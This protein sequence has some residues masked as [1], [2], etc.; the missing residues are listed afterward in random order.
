MIVKDMEFSVSSQDRFTSLFSFVFDVGG[1]LDLSLTISPHISQPVQIMFCT[2]K[3]LEPLRNA[4]MTFEAVCNELPLGLCSKEYTISPASTTSTA[5]VLSNGNLTADPIYTITEY[6]NIHRTATTSRMSLAPGAVPE[7]TTLRGNYTT[8]FDKVPFVPRP[9]FTAATMAPLSSLLSSVASI[10]AGTDLDPSELNLDGDIALRRASRPAYDSAIQAGLDQEDAA[11]LHTADLSALHLRSTLSSTSSSTSATA[12]TLSLNLAPAA[13]PDVHITYE[14]TIP[15]RDRYRLLQLNCEEIEYKGQLSYV[16]VNPGGEYLSLTFVPYKTMFKYVGIGFS[17]FVLAWAW[18]IYRHRHFNI[19]AQLVLLPVPLCK[20]V[21]SLVSDAYWNTA[22]TTGTAPSGLYWLSFL[23]LLANRALIFGTVLILATGYGILHPRVPRVFSS[24]IATL[25]GFYTLAYALYQ[26]DFAMALLLMIVNY[27]FIW[28]LFSL[29][30]AFTLRDVGVQVEALQRHQ[31]NYIMTPLYPKIDIIRRLQPAFIVYILADLISSMWAS[32][33]AVSSPWV[34]DTVEHSAA[35]AMMLLLARALWLSNFNPHLHTLALLN[36][37]ALPSNIYLAIAQEL[38]ARITPATHGYHQ[39]SDYRVQQLLPDTEVTDDMMYG[40]GKRYPSPLTAELLRHLCP[41]TEGGGRFGHCL[42]HAPCKC[43]AG[44]GSSQGAEE[45][46][47][48]SGSASPDVSGGASP[49]AAQAGSGYFRSE[50]CAHIGVA[51][52]FSK[53][54]PSTLL[55][56][57]MA[58]VAG[59]RVAAGQRAGTGAGAGTGSGVN[60]RGYVVATSSY[61]GEPV[62]PGGGYGSDG[63]RERTRGE[64][65]SPTITSPGRSLFGATSQYK[66]LED[67]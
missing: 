28:Q 35:M 42:V 45:A 33:V 50:V 23:L 25:V 18:H 47:N 65:K 53:V 54:A 2:D 11:R 22:S 62:C 13:T 56:G 31:I 63:I 38:S 61:Q 15:V 41:D 64:N 27:A 9:R 19:S 29:F 55:A 40:P 20:A 7:T 67:E 30:I 21:L 39:H 12:S 4:Y 26:M 59:H 6:D 66:R 34:Q 44:T 46:G 10:V 32:M 24:R 17:L 37:T 8:V 1:S 57:H 16:A 51:M 43:G 58:A 49:G 48:G 14:D 60:G 3:E 36:T 5:N 52:L